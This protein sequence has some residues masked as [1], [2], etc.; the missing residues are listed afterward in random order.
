MLDIR[1]IRQNPGLYEQ[2]CID[3]NYKSL[4]RNSWKITE[5]FQQ[6]QKSQKEAHHLRERNNQLRRI[7][8]HAV[9]FSGDAEGAMSPSEEQKS[10]LEEARELKKKLE[11]FNE[12]E[13]QLNMEMF[14]LALELPNL[15]SRYTPVGT[16]PEVLGYIND[17]LEPPT[18]SSDRVW[19]SHVHIGTE[20]GLLDFEGA[21]KASGWG[22]YYLKN[23][24]AQLEQALIQYAISVAL[25]R[26]WK[27][28]SP[29][30]MVYAH[31]AAACGFQPRDQHGE[32]QIYAIEQSEKDRAKPQ[33]VLAGT[34]EIPLAGMMASEILEEP[35]L[36]L[37]M[38]GVSRCYR[39]EAGARGVD[40]KGLYRV[41]EF[42]KVEMFAWT[43]PD[44]TI[45]A[46]GDEIF[47][48]SPRL[49]SQ[50]DFVFNEM[51][52]IQQE[53]LRN[54]DLHCRILEMPTTDLGANAARKR[55]IEAFFPSRREKDDGWGEVSSLS[56][57]TDYQTRRLSTRV[58]VENDKPKRLDFPWT[59]NG[60]ALAVPRVLAAILENHWNDERLE[61]T[62][63]ECL[64]PWMGGKEVISANKEFQVSE[65][66]A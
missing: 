35:Q 43:M 19:R 8:A 26:G 20:L 58:V 24:A 65:V 14:N 46:Q 4:S 1:H 40:T 61:V 22:W 31:I 54:L 17:H 9:N 3:R 63:P 29:P 48:E 53:I 7:I 44:P 21:A 5:L 15:S 59:I 66:S 28:V 27:L 30:S 52:Q 39:A 12:L 42:T 62:I 49:D 55:D 11:S 45:G 25:K 60:T 38:I 18:S 41:H 64:R 47:K 33:M 16:K 36:P 51:L 2:N 50:A 34:A 10:A 32:Q 23:E 56:L 57:C 13:D 37:K 6:L